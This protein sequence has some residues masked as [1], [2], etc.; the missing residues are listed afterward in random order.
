MIENKQTKNPKKK[1]KTQTKVLIQPSELHK[2]KKPDHRK[3]IKDV[4]S[5]EPSF[6]A[7]ICNSLSLS[8]TI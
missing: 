4:E 1:K 2:L 7:A 5:W 3:Y 8:T 6:N